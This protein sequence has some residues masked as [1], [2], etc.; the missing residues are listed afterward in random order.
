MQPELSS[1]PD[2]RRIADSVLEDHRIRLSCVALI[3]AIS[4][5]LIRLRAVA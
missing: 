3:S 4:A 2:Q 5:G 1:L